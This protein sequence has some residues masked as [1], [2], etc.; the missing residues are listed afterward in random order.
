MKQRN[1]QYFTAKVNGEEI[2]FRCYTTS[3]RCGFCHTAISLDYDTTA[4]KVSYYNMTWE[5]FD[6]ETALCR[7]IDKLPA[8]VRGEVRAQIIDGKA[9]EEKDRAD[10]MFQDFKRLHDGLTDENKAR[11]ANSGITIQDEAGARAVMG[12]MGLMTLMQ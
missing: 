2:R 4:T 8:A 7:A 10:A 1:V 11:L 5:R 3:T 6:Y 9:A 12:L